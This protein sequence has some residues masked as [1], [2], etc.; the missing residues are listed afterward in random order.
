MLD[1][2]P[3]TDALAAIAVTV[4]DDQLTLP[5]PCEKV[6][7][8][9]LLDHVVGLSTGFT[10]AAHK[11]IPEGGSA[12]PR[13]DGSR[14]GDDWRRRITEGLARLAEVWR[15]PVAWSGMTEV[16]GVPVP[17]E[18]CGLIAVNEIVVHAWDIAVSTG[19]RYD[20]E[21]VHVEAARQFVQSN[22]DQNPDGVE[23]LFGPAVAVPGDAS[24]L[25]QLLGLTGR[26]PSWQPAATR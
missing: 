10:M 20:V 7:V 17:G 18:V 5:T 1:L 26:D 9:D 25:D 2:K 12:P 23:G 8:A 6:T 19:Q 4:T 3:A 13:A 22:V 14:L 11:Q 24:P 21:R 15:D 16:G